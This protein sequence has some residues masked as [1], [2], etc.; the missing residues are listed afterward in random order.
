LQLVRKRLDTYLFVDDGGDQYEY[1]N[2]PAFTCFSP[3]VKER[4]LVWRKEGTHFLRHVVVAESLLLGG[5]NKGLFA[6]NRDVDVDYKFG[7][8]TGECTLYTTEARRTAACRKMGKKRMEY[9]MECTRNGQPAIV[10]A[11]RWMHAFLR[12]INDPSGKGPGVENAHFDAPFGACSAHQHI[13]PFQ[14]SN[15]A[16]QESEVWAFYNSTSFRYGSESSR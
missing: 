3:G 5:G 8:Y 13:P 10:D 14:L 15:Q 4:T 11:R 9:S 12:Y 1:A 7:T 6:W 2:L 16:N